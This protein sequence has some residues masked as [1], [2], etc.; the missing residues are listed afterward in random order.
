MAKLIYKS[1]KKIW[2]ITETKMVADFK[3]QSI[4]LKTTDS[5]TITQ[6][7]L[8]ARCVKVQP[9]KDNR[10]SIIQCKTQPF[11]IKAL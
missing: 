10:H 5:H 11:R 4:I 3:V 8:R 6:L 1:L 9:I 2:L 7:R